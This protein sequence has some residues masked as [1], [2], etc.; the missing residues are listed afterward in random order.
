MKF[1]GKN[2]DRTGQDIPEEKPKK[3]TIKKEGIE[4]VGS[5]IDPDE[6]ILCVPGGK[7]YTRAE[8]EALETPAV[9]LFEMEGED[10]DAE[11]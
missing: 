11:S 10:D 3:P 6:I 8:L 9:S 5:D 4:I 1:I 2:G 7:C